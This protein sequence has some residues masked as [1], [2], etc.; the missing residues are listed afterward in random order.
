MKQRTSLHWRKLLSLL[1]ITLTMAAPY[2]MAVEEADLTYGLRH[3]WSFD[4]AHDNGLRDW[5]GEFE[6][7]LNIK[8]GVLTPGVAGQ[9]MRVLPPSHAR[10][11]GTVAGNLCPV[12]MTIACWIRL[13]DVAPQAAIFSNGNQSQPKNKPWSFELKD[14]CLVFYAGTGR[15]LCEDKIPQER[16]VHVAAVVAKA[17]SPASADSSRVRLYV[18]GREAGNGMVTI[19]PREA[20]PL[21]GNSHRG[22]NHPLGGQ[23]DELA[24][25]ERAFSASEITDLV[26]LGQE[27]KAISSLVTERQTVSLKAKKASNGSLGGE[28]VLSRDS[29]RGA[30]RVHV[31]TSGLGIPGTDYEPLAS[32]QIIPDGVREIRIPVR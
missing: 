29:D 22:G 16:W 10:Y 1:L 30:L 8:G 14:G 12:D 28:F 7:T 32:I 5:A 27:R 17:E 26:Q 2:A 6:L 19:A 23:L 4:E 24:I 11:L 15:V 20:E 9:A 25:W 31:S 18:D 21:V 13:E 3:Y